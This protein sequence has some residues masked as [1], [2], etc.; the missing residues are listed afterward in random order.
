[1]DEYFNIKGKRILVTG[2]SSGIGRGI[3]ERLANAGAHLYL[4]GRN[5]NR[6]DAVTHSLKG[7]KHRAFLGDL[8]SSEIQMH[9]TAECEKLDGVVLNAG[10]IELMPFQIHNDQSVRKIM[11]VNYMAPALLLQRLIKNRKI[12]RNASIIVISSVTSANFGSIGGTIYGSSKGALEGLVKSL[13]V[14]L[15]RQGIRVNSISPGIIETEAIEV[16]KKSLGE[17]S[18]QSDL[19]KYPLGRYGEPEDVASAVHFLMS[20]SSSWITGTNL[21]VD[22]G[23]TAHS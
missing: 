2:S 1:M 4:C 12:S 15:G 21:V 7:N 18:F 22:G 5:K 14:E 6:L 23:L 3:S 17:E 11:E 10:L 16:L 13:S 8:T 9:I 20:N 19:K